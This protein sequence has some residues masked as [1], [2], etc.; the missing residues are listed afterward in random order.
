MCC[1]LIHIVSFD[2]LYHII[3]VSEEGLEVDIIRATLE[4]LTEGITNLWVD[5]AAHGQTWGLLAYISSD[6]TNGCVHH[7]T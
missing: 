1:N 4:I 5:G 7:Q 6:G 2:N 3:H